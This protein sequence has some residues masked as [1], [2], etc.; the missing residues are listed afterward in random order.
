[1]IRIFKQVQFVCHCSGF[2]ARFDYVVLQIGGH[3]VHERGKRLSVA[4]S[5]SSHSLDHC[6]VSAVAVVLYC[7]MMQTVYA[8][9]KVARLAYGRLILVMFCFCSH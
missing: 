2:A 6:H 4:A 3:P 5:A 7:T 9:Q 1:M 8:Q